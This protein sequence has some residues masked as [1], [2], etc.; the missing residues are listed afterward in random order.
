MRIPTGVTTR[1]KTILPTLAGVPVEAALTTP[2]VYYSLNG[3]T[4]T[5]KTSPTVTH[6]GTNMAGQHKILINFGTTLTAGNDEEELAVKITS[7]D[8]DPIHFTLEVYRPKATEGNTLGVASDGDISGNVDGNVVGSVASVTA[9]VVLPTIPTNWIAAAGIAASALDGKGDWNINKT[10]YTVSALGAGVI[11]AA[12]IAASALDGKGDWNINKTGYSLTQAFPTNFA[13]LAITVTTGKVTVGTNDDKTGYTV[14]TLGANV[15]TAASIA[16]SALDGKGDWNINKTGYT[17]S[18]IGAGVI[19]AASIAASALDG[20]GDWNTLTPLTAAGIRSAVGLAAAN[21]DTQFTASATATGFG[22]AAELAKVP[23]SDG[24]VTWNATAL[25]SM[26]A[27]MNAGL[28][29]A[30]PELSVAVPSVTPSIRTGLMLG[31]MMNRNQYKVQTSGT[32]ALEVYNDAGTLITKK[33]LTDDGSDYVEA[34]M[35]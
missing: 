28:D 34:K 30:I 29:A 26:L 25:A 14:S 9:A 19:T 8:C 2:V 10:G 18:A 17:I 20:K 27:Q 24:V 31:Y 33:L 35:T 4:V 5:Q 23:K 7:A 3:G 32:D 21:M 6:Q 1:Y 16:A 11:T 22:T 15:I 12:S 13:D